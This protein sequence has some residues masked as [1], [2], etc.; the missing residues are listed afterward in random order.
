[1]IVDAARVDGDVAVADLGLT[2]G[3]REA[4]RVEGADDRV[5]PDDAVG[6]RAGLVGALG[7]GRSDAPSAQAEDGDV[8]PGHPEGAALTDRNLIDRAQPM[9]DDGLGRVHWATAIGAANWFA[10][11][12]LAASVCQGS[13]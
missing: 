5:L 2:C 13:T 8:L 4:P 11:A 12:G 10:V 9:F 7:L 6:E 3:E 1:M